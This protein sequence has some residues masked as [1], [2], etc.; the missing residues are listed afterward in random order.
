MI[1]HVFWGS[2]P[3]TLSTCMFAQRI[4]ELQTCQT[5]VFKAVY[6]CS[7]LVKSPKFLVWHAINIINNII[8]SDW[9]TFFSCY[10]N[11]NTKRHSATWPVT[12]A[13]LNLSVSKPGMHAVFCHSPKWNAKKKHIS[14]IVFLKSPIKPRLSG[15]VPFSD[16]VFSIGRFYTTEEEFTVKLLPGERVTWNQNALLGTWVLI[17]I[18]G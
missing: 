16:Q 11:W 14:H 10:G 1:Q 17:M 2:F 5:I 9:C 18:H 12:E 6:C 13:R 3:S 4:S 15:S 8:K 7:A